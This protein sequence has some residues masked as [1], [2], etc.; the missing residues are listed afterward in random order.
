MCSFRLRHGSPAGVGDAGGLPPAQQALQLT[1][2]YAG[3]GDVA[4]GERSATSICSRVTCGVDAFDVILYR[5][6]VSKRSCE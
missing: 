6:A 2:S 3:Q 1:R 5:R 4:P